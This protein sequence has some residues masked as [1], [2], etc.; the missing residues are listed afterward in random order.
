MLGSTRYFAVPAMEAKVFALSPPIEQLHLP[1]TDHMEPTLGQ[2]QQ[3]VAFISEQVQKG[4]EE[5][6]SRVLVH[7]KAGVRSVAACHT[8]AE[9]GFTRLYSM[10]GGIV[11]WAKE[12]DTNLPVY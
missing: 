7:C 9:L 10:D 12:V 1:V 6:K 8:L 5:G 2:L 4:A 11:A 3:A